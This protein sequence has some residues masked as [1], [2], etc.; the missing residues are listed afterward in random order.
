MPACPIPNA[1]RLPIQPQ[2][3]IRLLHSGEQESQKENGIKNKPSPHSEKRPGA[4]AGCRDYRCI[5]LRHASPSKPRYPEIN[6][7]KIIAY[8]DFLYEQNPQN[9]FAVFFHSI[10]LL[11]YPNLNLIMVHSEIEGFITAPAVSSTAPTPFFMKSRLFIFITCISFSEAEF[12][13][14][15][16][17]SGLFSEL[18]QPNGVRLHRQG[19]PVFIQN[20]GLTAPQIG[21]LIGARFELQILKRPRGLGGTIHPIEKTKHDAI[22]QFQ[23]PYPGNISTRK[24]VDRSRCIDGSRPYHAKYC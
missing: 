2:C 17:G 6:N 14:G 1:I 11:L 15:V 12:H 13:R 4:A 18:D 20:N 9:P 19:E 24:E 22:I 10:G 16:M 23:L 7:L 21:Q 8:M 3:G 5:N